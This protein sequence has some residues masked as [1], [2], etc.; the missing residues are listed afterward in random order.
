MLC[1]ETMYFT[2]FLIFIELF[3][4]MNLNGCLHEMT[5]INANLSTLCITVFHVFFLF[6]NQPSQS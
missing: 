2:L 6:Y 1:G 5:P 3:S 4:R